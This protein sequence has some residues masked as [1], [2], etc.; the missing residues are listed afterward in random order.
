MV[1]G[2]LA[3]SSC[4]AKITNIFGTTRFNCPKCGEEEIVRCTR[5]RK[6]AAK[7]ACNKCGFIGP[8]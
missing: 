5:C 8:N 3:C 1:E 6:I 2:K 7:Y 4:K